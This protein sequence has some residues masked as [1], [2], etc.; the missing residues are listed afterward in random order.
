MKNWQKVT[1]GALVVAAVAGGTRAAGLW[2]ATSADDSLTFALPTPLNGLDTSKITDE[3]SINIAGNTNE[4]LLRTDADGKPQPALAQKVT[5]S[6][7]GKTWTIEL[8]EGLK[9]SNDEALTAADVVYGWQRANDPKTASEYAYLYSGILNADKIQA[10][11]ADVSTLGVKATSDTTLE[12]T[13][14]KP[15][16]QFES[17]LTFPTFY[18][19]QKKFV[20]EKGSEYASNSDNQVYSGPYILEGWNGSNNSFKLVKNPNYWDADSVKSETIN[21]QVVQK[22]DT[23]LQLYKQGK[24]ATTPLS[25]AELLQA[26]KSSDDYNVTPQAVTVFTYYNTTEKGLNNAKIRQALNLA[27]DRETLNNEVLSGL[28]TPATT[29]TPKGLY[30]TSSGDDFATYASQDYKVDTAEAKKLW[31]EGLKEL[32]VDSLT[33]ELEADTDRVANGKAVAEYLQGAWQDTLPGLTVK[34]KL[35]PFKQ[36]LEDGKNGNF[37]IMLTQWGA[38]YAE[39]LTYLD[40]LTSDGSY[41]WGKFKSAAYDKALTEATTVNATNDAARAENYKTIESV[42]HDEAAVNPLYF[43]ASPELVASDVKS[44]IRNTAG[45]SLDLKYA[46]RAD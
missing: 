5:P 28:S 38:D 32:G 34:T 43:Q 12:V 45:V 46:H 13:L 10:G 3:Y 35:V 25:T 27:T 2:G 39:P 17:L 40:M 23:S 37:Q 19:L 41:N 7:D 4:G 24:L 18:P 11:E 42:I 14:E 29:Y 15:L 9:W 1:A 16:P 6:S 36:R 26:N 20:E 31:E 33:L 30:T 44:V 8:R 21:L 22:P